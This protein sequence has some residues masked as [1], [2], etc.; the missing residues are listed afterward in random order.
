MLKLNW[1][2][3]L[4]FPISALL[5]FFLGYQIDRNRPAKTLFLHQTAYSKQILTRASLLDTDL[6]TYKSP[7]SSKAHG[8][9]PFDGQH[10]FAETVGGLLYLSNG[11]RPDLSYSVHQLCRSMHKPTPL[12]RQA[13]LRLLLY[14]KG[15]ISHGI[16]Q[17]LLF[18]A[19]LMRIINARAIAAPPLALCS[20]SI[21][22]PL[23]GAAPPK[24]IQLCL[25]V[26]PNMLH[27]PLPHRKL[28]GFARF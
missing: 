12:D 22:A 7:A 18:V 20:Y 15:T 21:M 17:S 4:S 9:I 8:S 14:L 11:T 23:V 1:L 2:L 5:V 26:S 6:Y 25:V 24:V 13:L 27:C 10:N 19:L 3:I 28:C 16:T